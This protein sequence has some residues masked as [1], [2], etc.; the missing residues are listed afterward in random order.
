MSL[1]DLT[2]PAISAVAL[3]PDDIPRIY[4]L[5]TAALAAV[6]DPSAVR[7]DAPAFFEAIFDVGGEIIGLLADGDLVGYGVLRPELDREHDRV[8]LDAH[9]PAGAPMRVL[10]GSAVHPRLWT[11]GLQ[12]TVVDLR[13][14]RAADLG[15]THV[16]AKASPGNVPSMRNLTRCG[17]HIVGLVLK[18][19]GWRYVHVR[20]VAEPEPEPVG[21]T[22]QVAAEVELSVARFA[23]GEV[24]YRAKRDAEG[25]PMLLF[26]RKG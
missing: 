2:E 10:D 12:R 16:I 21:G 6:P 23:A 15:A 1:A 7:A 13:I 14:A 26:G 3:A 19:Y 25:V 18:P 9:V 17:F 20:P 5:Y 8:G 11:H 4:A 22:W 24:A